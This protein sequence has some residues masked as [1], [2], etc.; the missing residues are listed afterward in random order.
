MRL[1]L[2]RALV[3]AVASADGRW[4]SA[5]LK[6]AA[7]EG[8]ALLCELD[9]KH[10]AAVRD[11]L[12]HPHA[13]AWAVRCM[14]T[15]KVA[16]PD[17]DRAHLAGLAAAAALRAGLTVTL[18]VP[19]RH[20]ALYFPTVGALRVGPGPDATAVVSVSPGRVVAAG[21]DGEWQSARRISGG[22]FQVALDD[23]DPF[24]DCHGWPAASRLEPGQALAWRQ[25]ISSAGQRLLAAVPAYASVLGAGLRSIV[26]LS[27]PPSG[28]RS[29]TARHAFGAI[30]LA[31]P[32][33]PL[34]VD[35]LIVHEFQHSKLHALVDLHELFDAADPRRLRVP[36]RAD[37]RPVEGALHG[38]Y[39]HLALAH[40]WQARGL[41]GRARHLRYR[42]WVSQA[43]TALL[44]MGA[45][46]ADGERFVA[47]MATAAQSDDS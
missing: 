37:P 42:S 39:A 29:A 36:W 19:V 14:T 35:D 44:G 16:D 12:A 41:D 21:R 32:A 18:P 24:R 13:R 3:A 30:A 45:L 2:T 9:V 1:S 8:W 22:L 47:G 23:L 5:D 34:G 15:S 43:C 31:L 40:L 27:Q 7:A 25:A 11:V 20:G 33:A 4:Q 10:P 28:D 46:T 17:L 26:P 38:A 6:L